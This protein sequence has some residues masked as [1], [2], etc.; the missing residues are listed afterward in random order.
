MR[1]CWRASLKLHL[2]RLGTKGT[3]QSQILKK[4]NKTAQKNTFISFNITGIQEVKCKVS[5]LF[6]PMLCFSELRRFT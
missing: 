5:G 4:K 3:K 1:L 2:V 6:V